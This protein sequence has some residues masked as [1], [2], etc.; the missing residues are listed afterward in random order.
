M[1]T[2]KQER[3]K[4]ADVCQLVQI[5]PYVLRTWE[6]EFSD[7]G[8][9]T[10]AGSRVYSKRDVDRVR[11]IH[12]LVYGEGLTLAGARK[13]LEETAAEAADAAAD[14]AVEPAGEAFSFVDDTV[15]DRLRS[16]RAGLAGVLALLERPLD[17]DRFTLVPSS[18]APARRAPAKPARRNA[19]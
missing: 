2:L 7:L 16:V 5:Q 3:L 18:A 15:R 8:Q 19:R 10:P 17:G 14:A 6:A 4:A 12:E 1:A 13:R 9:A 11:L